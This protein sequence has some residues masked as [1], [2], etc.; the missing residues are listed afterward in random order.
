MQTFE[1]GAG[2]FPRFIDKI[3]QLGARLPHL[4]AI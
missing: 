3:L 1:E 4:D 2:N